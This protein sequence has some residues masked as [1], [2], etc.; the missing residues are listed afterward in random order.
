MSTTPR[1]PFGKILNLQ[2]CKSN[3]TSGSDQIEKELLNLGCKFF[4]DG[5]MKL[6]NEVKDKD[7]PYAEY[8]I[9]NLKIRYK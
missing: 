3:D 1:I 2:N 7:K 5:V 4:K 8:L 6:T 9:Y